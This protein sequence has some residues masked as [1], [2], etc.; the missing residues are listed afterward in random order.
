MGGVNDWIKERGYDDDFEPT[1]NGEFIPTGTLVGSAERI[2]VYRKRVE[3][4]VPLW[5]PDDCKLAEL[6]WGT[7]RSPL[8]HLGRAAIEVPMPRM[9]RKSL[10]Q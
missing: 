2:E 5:H 6:K 3:R 7:P 4:G 10:R 8:W 9:Q 1:V